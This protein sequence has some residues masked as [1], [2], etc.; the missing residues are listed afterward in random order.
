[1]NVPEDVVFFG[2]CSDEVV[3]VVDG[4]EGIKELDREVCFFGIMLGWFDIIVD[5][6]W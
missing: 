3:R 4:G 2:V 6:V 1:M 5:C